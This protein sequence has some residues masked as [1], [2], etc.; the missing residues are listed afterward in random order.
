MSQRSPAEPALE[1]SNVT[2]SFR[3]GGDTVR[4]VRGIDLTIGRGE[5]V[6]LLGA[7]GAGK[8][9]T[10]DMVL[11]LTAPTTGTVRILG[12]SAE[13][14]VSEGR[15]SAVLQTG[16]LLHDLRVGETVELIARTYR[17]HLDPAE[18]LRRTGLERLA[19]RRVSKCSGG[20]QQRL[21]FAL[22]LL[23]EP[24]LLILDEP[25]AGMDVTARR[26]FWAAMRGEA[27]AGRTIIF[28]THYRQEADEFAQRIVMMAGG[29]I[30]ADGS[31]AEVRAIAGRKHV[32]ARWPGASD[33]DLAAVPA[34]D[35]ATR[36]DERVTFESSD[37][38]AT[39][40][41][42]LTATD[43]SDLEIVAASLDDAFANLADEANAAATTAAASERRA[44]AH[45]TASVTEPRTR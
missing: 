19:K 18:V 13:D 37:A 6:A 12:G 44:A 7:N 8:T 10:L 40:R 27:S 1:L 29:E 3:S 14:A 31:V 15:I 33:A 28:A 20:E 25:T 21:R 22:S 5:I 41:H 26:E 24:E 35:R 38:D 36:T 39:A 23:S 30:V 9:T 16:G 32:S 34:S 11:G 42:L 43:A 2:K 4:A 17:H 45:A